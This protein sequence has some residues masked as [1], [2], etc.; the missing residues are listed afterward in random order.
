MRQWIISI[1]TAILAI[2]NSMAMDP[3]QD[4]RFTDP[5]GTDHTFTFQAPDT[6]AEWEARAELLRLHI[7]AVNGLWPP[8]EPCPLN[9]K[10]FDTITHDD[11]TVSK[12][13]FESHPGYYVTGNLYQPRNGEGPFPA[14]LNPHGHWGAGRFTDVED[15]SIQARCI[16]FARM[17]A[18]AF[19]YDMSGYSDS[20]HF[21]HRFSCPEWELWGIHPMALQ[22]NNAMRAIDFLQDLPQ[23]DPE[24]IGCTGASGGGTQ[25]FIATAV[26]P[27]IKVAAPVNMVSGIMQGGCICENA[28]YLRLDT[29]NIEIGA[30]AAPRPLLLVSA[31]GDWTRNTLQNEGPMIQAVYDRLYAQPDR[32][33]FVQF[34]APHNYNQSSREAVYAW[35][36]HWLIGEPALETSIPELPYQVDPTEQIRIFPEQG[37]IPSDLTPERLLAQWKTACQAQQSALWPD[38]EAALADFRRTYQTAFRRVLGVETMSPDA[39]VI[40]RVLSRSVDGV[41]LYLGWNGC[42]LPAL[43]RKGSSQAQPEQVLVLV[44]PDGIAGIDSVPIADHVAVL[45]FDP[46]LIGAHRPPEGADR[47]RDQGMFGAF[48][49]TD[50]SCR[51]QDVLIAVAAARQLA[52]KAEIHL[53]G[54]G[55]GGAWALFARGVLEPGEVSAAQID[56]AGFALN[57]DQDWIDRMNIPAVRRLGGIQTAIGLAGPEPLQIHGAYVNFPKQPV[58]RLYAGFDRRDRLTIE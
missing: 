13:C 17:G 23:V 29:N 57:S 45:G 42:V 24:R 56:F 35:F 32:L 12:V 50:D 49:P 53:H 4:A 54:T 18:I 15:G 46:F 33:R 7:L 26:D 41:S 48:H 2:G 22:L 9:A 37:P 5:R 6:L 25:T 39:V 43:W 34:D 36:A 3:A 20:Q 51:I 8:P 11:Y 14:I 27:R 58:L 10:V 1:T 44:H 52:P 21:P 47:K 30:L 19:A 40:E 55:A 28:P 16:Q 31:T 38:S